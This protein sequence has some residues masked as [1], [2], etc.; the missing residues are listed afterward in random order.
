MSPSHQNPRTDTSLVTDDVVLIAKLRDGDPTALETLA[1][2]YSERLIRYA[3]RWVE[4]VDRAHEVVQDVFLSLWQERSTL[5]VTKDVAAYLF[6]RTRNH[7][8]DIA[9]ADRAAHERDGR[10]MTEVQ[11]SNAMRTTAGE[12]AL[13]AAEMQ[14]AIERAIAS[15]PDRCREVF[16]LVWSEHL[17]YTEVATV[18]GI[19]VP[20][21]RSQM[22]RAVKH[23]ISVLGPLWGVS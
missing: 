6:W 22:S 15:A 21:V 16:M 9:H 8:I 11:V 14:A 13:E 19:A 23:L 4:S 20:T 2:I 7:A 1:R 3:V 10:W 17:S 5:T 18:L 12:D